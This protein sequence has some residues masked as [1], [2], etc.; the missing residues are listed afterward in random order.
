[1]QITKITVHIHTNGTD[2]VC[3]HTNLPSP[4]PPELSEQSP[5]FSTE[6]QA[7]H[8]IQYA[9]DNLDADIPLWTLDL[10]NG[11]RKQIR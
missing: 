5:Q 11:E 3:L 8:G 6:V 4:F 10:R 7:G 9:L 2:R 1:M